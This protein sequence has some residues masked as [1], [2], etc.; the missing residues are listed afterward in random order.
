MNF[1]VTKDK[2][3]ITIQVGLPKLVRDKKT[4]LDLNRVRLR[5]SHINDYLKKSNI[6]VG[7][8]LK[9]DN[10]NNMGDRLVAIWKYEVP[11]KKVVDKTPKTV[12]TSDRAKRTRKSSKS[13]DE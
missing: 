6:K 2:D 13:K 10:L 7:K 11:S 1:T 8:C 3:I 5:E 9:K 12:V 4:R